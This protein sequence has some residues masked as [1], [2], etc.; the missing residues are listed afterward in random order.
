MPDGISRIVQQV[1]QWLKTGQAQLID[2]W[3]ASQKGEGVQC[4]TRPLEI[5]FPMTHP[6]AQEAYTKLMEAVAEAFQGATVWE[7]TGY[8]CNAPP[9]TLE[10]MQ[11]Q[12]NIEP[13]RVISVWHH[14]TDEKKRDLLARALKEAEE[15]TEQTS[16]AVRATNRFYSIPTK[17]LKLPGEK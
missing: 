14:C 16:I 7:G 10:E 5:F 1:R 6:R 4:H 12:G 9:C 15:M 13:V 8:W 11:R 3:L 17:Q 2:D